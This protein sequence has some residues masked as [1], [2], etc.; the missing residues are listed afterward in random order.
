MGSCFSS[1]SPVPEDNAVPQNS[2]N[3]TSFK[4][5]PAIE[6][7]T[8][9]SQTPPSTVGLSR[10]R[11]FLFGSGDEKRQA[12]SAFHADQ[13]HGLYQLKP[14]LEVLGD[15]HMDTV[16][17]SGGFA[18]VLRGYWRGYTEVAVKV[19]ATTPDL[20]VSAD[21][22]PQLPVRALAEALLA[23]DLAHPN[24]IKT[25]DVRCCRLSPAFMEALH[26][27]HQGLHALSLDPAHFSSGPDG[28]PI[29]PHQIMA[30]MDEHRQQVESWLQALGCYTGMTPLWARPP[31][32]SQEWGA[33]SGDMPT[34]DGF[35]AAD[36]M[37]GLPGMSWV[38]VLAHI[39]AKPND[40]VTVIIMQHANF[41]TLWTAI[42]AGCCSRGRF[43]TSVRLKAAGRLVCVPLPCCLMQNAVFVRKAS[44]T[45]AYRRAR[46]RAL[47]RTAREI[48][49]GLEHL[50]ACNVVH[51]DI[52]PANVL[53]HDS[54]ADSRGFHAL[55]TDFGLSKLVLGSKHI[56]KNASGTTNYMAPELFLDREVSRSTDVYA[57]GIMLWEMVHGCPAYYPLHQSQVLVMVIQGMR[58]P[59]QAPP[60]AQ[61][62]ALQGIYLR[63]VDVDAA[64]RPS[65]KQ[66]VTELARL[67]DAA[68]LESRKESKAASAR[69]PAANTPSTAQHGKAA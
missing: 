64:A 36:N 14:E 60:E 26:S 40:F 38:E 41:G 45:G 12:M 16:L 42:K 4:K 69:Q 66:L 18:C 49:M 22:Q 25:Y 32:S 28:Q 54:R 37:A 55:L 58:P 5:E 62:P 50:H 8:P 47:L 35:G 59:W 30:C 34:K 65:A 17:G 6:P 1:P 13:H 39:G 56:S 46:L 3:I 27:Q 24:I 51:G 52:K 67:E 10:P 33:G 57:F 21:V 7:A 11:G 48:A 43:G 68:R 20:T 63:C 53:L 23:R 44:A 15:L 9:S 61:L 2:E 29:A 19:F 31:S